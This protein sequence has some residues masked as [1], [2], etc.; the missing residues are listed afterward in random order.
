VD[1]YISP[2]EKKQHNQKYGNFFKK[3]P[4]LNILGTGKTKILYWGGYL[5]KKSR[6]FGCVV[7]FI[8]Y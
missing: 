8:A 1:T 7:F 3:Y 6:I 2:P 5:D 4:H